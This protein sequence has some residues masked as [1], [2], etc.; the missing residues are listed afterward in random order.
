MKMYDYDYA[1]DVKMWELVKYNS[2]SAEWETQ[3]V[4]AETE[5]KAYDMTELYN[6]RGYQKGERNG[7]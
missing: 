6:K 7:N 3:G 5:D 1:D 4:Y 2:E